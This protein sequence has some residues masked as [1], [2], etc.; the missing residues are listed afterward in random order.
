MKNLKNHRAFFM[1][2]LVVIASSLLLFSFVFKEEISFEI[3]DKCG[4]FVNL[5]SHTIA[6]EDACASRCL[7]QC[8]SGDKKFSKIIFEEA[9]KGCH[10]CTCFCKS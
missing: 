3:Q 4:V 7:G 9:E 5:V 10:K 2:L 1:L 6:D 8:V